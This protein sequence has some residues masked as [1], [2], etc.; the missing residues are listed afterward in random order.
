MTLVPVAGAGHTRPV[1]L[2]A[3]GNAQERPHEVNTLGVTWP[4]GGFAWFAECSCGWRGER[5]L[6]E[7]AADYDRLA[8]CGEHPSQD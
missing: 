6:D 4:D 2:P 3:A 5:R 7:F 8:P 1:T